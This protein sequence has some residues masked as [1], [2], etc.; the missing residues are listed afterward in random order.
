MGLS[1]RRSSARGMASRLPLQILERHG[2]GV[3]NEYTLQHH[4]QPRERL[5][6]HLRRH[7]W[8]PLAMEWHST[9]SYRMRTV[10][11]LQSME[12]R[13]CYTFRRS[14]LTDNSGPLFLTPGLVIAMHVTG[15]HFPEPERLELIRYILGKR[16][17]EGG[18]GLC[19]LVLLLLKD[20]D[21]PAIPPLLPPFSEPL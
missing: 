1:A 20:A 18:W 9:A 14:K 4:T 13:R 15:Q 7:L 19:V 5:I 17:P 21:M 10:T 8:T 3:S 6:Y 16:R 12:V 11:S 2:N